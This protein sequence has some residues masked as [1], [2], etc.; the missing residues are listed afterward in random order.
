MGQA[1]PKETMFNYREFDPGCQWPPQKLFNEFPQKSKN[2]LAKSGER[3]QRKK[4]SL[5]QCVSARKMAGDRA[6]SPNS[7]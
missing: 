5:K 7:V 2:F 3:N 4:Y 6:G 1:I